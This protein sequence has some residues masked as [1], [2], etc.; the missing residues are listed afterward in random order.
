MIPLTLTQALGLYSIV[1]GLM[2]LAIWIYTE[3][4]VWRPIRVLERQ[5]VWR[6]TFCGYTYLD[7]SGDYLSKC[8]RCESINS[9][10]DKNAKLVR[11]RIPAEDKTH[12]GDEDD[13]RRNPSRRKRPHQRRRGPRRR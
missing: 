11:M 2:V 10:E 13:Q 8:P 5:H 1:L 6:C 9:A 12:D 4:S 3:V 7:E